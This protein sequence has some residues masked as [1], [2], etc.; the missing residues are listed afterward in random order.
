MESADL[1]QYEK[2]NFRVISLLMA[3]IAFTF[4][5]NAIYIGAGIFF[6]LAG[7]LSISYQG[8]I[9]DLQWNRYMKYDRFLN[10]RIGSWKTLSKPSYVTIVRIKLSN[11]RSAPSPIVAPEDKKGAR[12]FKVNLV[13]DG[14]ERYIPICHGPRQ[15][16]TLEALRLGN[17]LQLRVLDYTTHE[18]KWIS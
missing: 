4:L 3:L 5:F 7:L 10:L 2:Y 14:D 17:Y 1:Y 11:R 6:V 12:A 13:V 15:K 16:M 18:K 9:I 8:V